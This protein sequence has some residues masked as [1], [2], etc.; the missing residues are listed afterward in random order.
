MTIPPVYILTVQ[1]LCTWRLVILARKKRVGLFCDL[2][3]CISPLRKVG[4]F[5]HR[6][7]LL[8][9]VVESVETTVS[10]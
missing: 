3:C 1:D 2:T 5:A 6:W 8:P 4:P 7:L 9:M 10:K